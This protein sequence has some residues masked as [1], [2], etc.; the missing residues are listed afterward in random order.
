[1]KRT[2]RPV[3]RHS[4]G[5]WYNWHLADSFGGKLF[6]SSIHTEGMEKGS[7]ACKEVARKAAKEF[8][9]AHVEAD[10]HRPD[11]SEIKPSCERKTWNV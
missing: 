11:M 2:A 1:M 10:V 3:I 8:N 4:T 6:H 5:K 7:G 9:A